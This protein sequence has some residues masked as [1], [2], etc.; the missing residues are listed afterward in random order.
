MEIDQSSR[1]AAIENA[2]R[3]RVFSGA[4]P[5]GRQHI[6]N[7]LGAIRNYVAL[8]DEADCYYCIVDYHALTTLEQTEKIARNTRDM[9][10]D[11]LA[12]GIDPSRTVIFA[13]SDVPEITEL[14]VLLSMIVPLAWLTR[15]PTFRE[16]SEDHPDNVNYGVLGYPVLM[17]SDILLYKA[18]TVPVGED[19]LPHLELAREIAR[20]FNNRFGE[21]FPVPQARLTDFPRVMGIDGTRKM[22]KSLDNHIELADT[23]EDLRTRVLSMVTDPQRRY[24]T[25][26]GRPEVCNVYT[27]HTNYSSTDEQA[28]VYH[29]C[30]NA[31]QGCVE[32]KE[33]L[34]RNLDAALRPFRERREAFAANPRHVDEILGDGAARARSVSRETL[35][36][37]RERV[38]LRATPR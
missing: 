22:S 17:A 25:D 20:R 37:V 27:L 34:S 2:A 1:G 32:C 26:P 11:W 23:P 24:R 19:Q 18:T 16:Q 10:L 21:T 29:R 4:R 7:Y 6:G 15:A 5:T 8:Q 9:V 33:W 31:L 13:Q 35:R 36:E 28:E 3:A 30:T 14:H 38:G 12:A